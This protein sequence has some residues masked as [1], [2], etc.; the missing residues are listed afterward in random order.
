MLTDFDKRLL[1]LIQ[2]DLPLEKRPFAMIADK[3][4]TNENE[5]I[6]RLQFLKEQGF[7]RRIG[8]FFDSGRLGYVSTLVALKVRP[9]RMGLVA[10]AVN[11]YCGVTHNYEREGD[12][13][14]WFALISPSVSA[15]T[16]V[17]A[18]IE[19]LAGVEQLI[20][21]PATRKFKVSVQ[22]KL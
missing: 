16:K 9:E 20:S 3:L 22:F 14:L 6:E 19:K 10:K 21:L 18:E 1:N 7:I 4:G 17:L 15:Q 8:P 13:N 5:V 11:R 2:T 12:F